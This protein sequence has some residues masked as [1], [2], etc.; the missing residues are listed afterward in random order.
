MSFSPS[1]ASV[2]AMSSAL[3]SPSGVA[4]STLKSPVTSSS[5]PLGCLYIAL[6]TL[7]IVSVSSGAMYTP[8]MYHCRVPVTS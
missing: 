5:A 6:M 3:L 7:S 4:R 8:T 1:V 2:V